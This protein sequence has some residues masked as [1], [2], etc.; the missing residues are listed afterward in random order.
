[1]F[2]TKSVIPI[3]LTCY[4]NNHNNDNNNNNNNNIH[5]NFEQDHAF[6]CGFILRSTHMLHGHGTKKN[7]MVTCH[8]RL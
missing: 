6:V 4:N 2:K 7:G 8:G 3:A 5:A 1:M